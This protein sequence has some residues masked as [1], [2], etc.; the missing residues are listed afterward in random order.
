MS[1]TVPPSG[2]FVHEFVSTFLHDADSFNSEVEVPSV[3]GHWAAHGSQ[4]ASLYLQFIAT[5][6]YTWGQRLT[7]AMAIYRHKLALGLGEET[8]NAFAVNPR[9][10]ARSFIVAQVATMMTDEVSLRSLYDRFTNE[11]RVACITSLLRTGA[12][13]NQEAVRALRALSIS[14]DVG[15]STRAVTVLSNFGTDH[16][17]AVALSNPGPAANIAHNLLCDRDETGAYCTMT[18]LTKSKSDTVA[19]AYQWWNSANHDCGTSYSSC[20]PWS[21]WGGESCGYSS[22]GGDCADFASQSM[23][24]GGYGPFNSGYPCRGYPCGKEEIGA[25]NLDNCLTDSLGFK[26]SCGKK[27]SVPS[28]LEPGDIIVYHESSCSSSSAHATVVTK[29]S[30]GSAK[31]TCHSSNHKD[32]DYTYIWD[33][34]PYTSF[35]HVK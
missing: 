23:I 34:H 16:D 7:A 15:T 28:W 3:L 18:Q 24:A 21:Y 27:P 33:S 22:Q 11:V 30:G 8:M 35:I 20:S 2:E 26:N 12:M 9:N 17:L 13:E 6:G 32:K 29:V 10:H 31:I 14:K 25:N 4:E 19:Y 5:T 1:S